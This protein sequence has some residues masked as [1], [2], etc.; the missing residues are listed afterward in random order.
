MNQYKPKDILVANPKLNFPG[1]EHFARFL[2]LLLR[3]DK[4]NRVFNK[5]GDKKG[6]AFAS[7]L[8]Q[9]LSIQ[10]SYDSDTFTKRIP[11]SGACIIISNQPFGGLESI[12]LIKILSEVRNDIKIVSTH[13]LQK[14]EPIGD[15]FLDG[16]PFSRKSIL[17]GQEKAVEHLTQGGILCLFPAGEV[18]HLDNSRVLSDRQW[19]IPTL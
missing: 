4:L 14:I 11:Q 5:I 2:M 9:I 19:Q 6:S 10:Y 18:S 13:L 8:L 16:N 12:L 7:E 3:F 1:G 17:P 15:Y